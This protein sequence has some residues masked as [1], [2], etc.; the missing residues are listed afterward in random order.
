MSN[1]ITDSNNISLILVH[2]AW[3]GAWA[4]KG[5]IA[6]LGEREWRGL[7][8][9]LPGRGNQPHVT[10]PDLRSYAEAVAAFAESAPTKKYILVGHGTAGAIIQLASEM[11]YKG[12]G[13]RLSGLIFAAAY[14]LQDGESVTDNMPPEMA[15]YFRQLA[16]QHPEQAIDMAAMKDYRL[17]SVINDDNRYA[18]RI[19]AKLTPEPLAPLEDKISLPSF[20]KNRPPCGYLSFNDDLTLPAGLYHPLMSS[21]LGAQR[22]FTVN[23][24][25]EAVIIKPREV[26]E[27]IIFLANGLLKDPH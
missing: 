6:Y 23:A 25:H 11:L 20:F 8:L 2:D 19:L 13:S 15:D 27:A 12:E 9:D 1:Q 22:L 4:W 17:N 18:D 5:V 10:K 14:I 21:R 24:G 16:G 26:A 3:H 7:A